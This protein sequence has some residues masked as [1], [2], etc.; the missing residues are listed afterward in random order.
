MAALCA[1]H[2]GKR[3]LKAWILVCSQF[4]LAFIPEIG[5]PHLGG[6]AY[7]LQYLNFSVVFIAKLQQWR[8]NSQ[9]IF[10]LHFLQ[11]HPWPSLG[12]TEALF[13]KQKL[14]MA[15]TYRTQ[16]VKHSFPFASTPLTTAAGEGEVFRFAINREAH[17]FTHHTN[18]LGGC[19]GAVS[20]C[21]FLLRY[22]AM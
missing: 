14:L 2:G 7:W 6:H 12:S 10:M 16:Q 20:Y 21:A 8:K 19:K 4:T 22:P 18:K 5:G 13:C 11:Q 1:G 17:N 15:V 9:G 3:P